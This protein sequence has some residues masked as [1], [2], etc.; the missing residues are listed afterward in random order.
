MDE[1]IRP[2]VLVGGRSRRF[3]RDKLREPLGEGWLVDRP[4][5]AL[6]DVFGPRVA[7]VGACDPEVSRRADGVIE[8]R[9]PGVGPVGGI[10]SALE[11]SGAAVFVLAG[12]MPLVTAAVVR[13]VLRGAAA[14]RNAWA[15]LAGCGFAEPCVGVYRQA[16]LG[17]L[18]SVLRAKRYRLR[19]ALPKE[20]VAVVSVPE[21]ALVN[22]NRPE[23]LEPGSGAK[24]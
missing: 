10:V 15:V 4:V 20:R 18:L 21:G 8:D 23:D 11:Q 5:A 17:T 16:A 9:Y 13:E 22:A 3:G 12:D 6:R 24:N 14:H 7:A 19:D 1:P 2:I